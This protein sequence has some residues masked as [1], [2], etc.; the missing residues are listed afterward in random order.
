MTIP[1][2]TVSF[3]TSQATEGLRINS[4]VMRGPGLDDLTE[5][6]EIGRMDLLGDWTMEVDPVIVY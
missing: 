1:S 6:V 2:G 5:G 3:S 4:R